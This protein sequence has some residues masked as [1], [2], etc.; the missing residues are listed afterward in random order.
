MFINSEPP[1]FRKA[2]DLAVEL[3]NFEVHFLVRTSYVD[4]TTLMSFDKDVVDSAWADEGRR[5]GKLAPSVIKRIQNGV[6]AHEVMP[7]KH[8]NLFKV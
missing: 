4:T 2:R 3:S 1:M 5:M 8:R 7:E 6:L